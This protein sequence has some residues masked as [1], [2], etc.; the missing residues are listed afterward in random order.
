MCNLKQYQYCLIVKDQLL[1]N[2]YK[3]LILYT[4]HYNNNNINFDIIIKI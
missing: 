2:L 4:L 3:Y 1:I